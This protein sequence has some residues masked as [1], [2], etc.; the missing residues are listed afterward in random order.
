MI[1]YRLPNSNLEY[2]FVG[3]INT[4]ISIVISDIIGD[5]FNIDLS[6]I[7]AITDD[8]GEFVIDLNDYRYYDRTLGIYIYDS[9]GALLLE[10]Y[11]DL[12]RPYAT[13]AVGQDAA[14]FYAQEAMARTIIDNV[15]GGF[16]LRRQ[17]VSYESL[18]GDVIPL[19]DNIIR[20]IRAWENGIKVFDALDS[21]FANTKIFGIS[22]D[23]SSIIISVGGY[24]NRISGNDTH[25]KWAAS[26]Y[27]YQT[28]DS[29]DVAESYYTG[30]FPKGTDYIFDVEIGYRYLPSDITTAANM[31][32]ASGQCTDQY[33]SKYI[34]EYSTDQYK[35]KYGPEA[36]VGT[37][38]RQVD[39]ILS[40]YVNQ[41]GSIRAGVL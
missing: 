1:I 6:S 14:T 15:T 31:L 2:K 28:F 27:L 36:F 24:S 21:S 23:R 13:P 30:V 39:M 26:D 12:V 22:H 8:A 18:G 34:S 17:I 41:G 3:P 9:F 29:I 10:D 20:I 11:V 4:S 19:R 33:L 32:I 25:P 35:V 16:Y 5:G 37:G 38:N 7:S 40:K